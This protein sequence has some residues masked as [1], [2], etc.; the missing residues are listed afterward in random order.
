MPWIGQVTVLVPSMVSV[1][2]SMRTG[3]RLVSRLIVLSG[4]DADDRGQRT[5]GG[6]AALEDQGIAEAIQVGLECGEIS[7]DEPRSAIRAMTRRM[8]G[9]PFRECN[10]WKT[11][12][13]QVTGQ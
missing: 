10:A 8:R 9:R 5:E 2:P 13:D 1:S 3:V 7:A 11:G 4:M 12:P 6:V